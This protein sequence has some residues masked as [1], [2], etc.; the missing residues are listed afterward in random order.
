MDEKEFK[1]RLA[2]AMQEPS[3]PP[4]LV[5]NTVKRVKTLEAGLMAERRLR[6]GRVPP[7]ERGPLLADSVLGRL[8]RSGTL[9]LGAD[10]GKLKN[11]L[12]HNERFRQ[13]SQREPKAVLD[14]LDNGKLAKR[15][16]QKKAAAPAKT[17]PKKSGPSL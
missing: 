4:D 14:A 11:Q 1:N 3:V 12:L 6:N 15:M 16:F 8:A 13:L 10:T 5:E 7:E 2:E 17:A 9:P